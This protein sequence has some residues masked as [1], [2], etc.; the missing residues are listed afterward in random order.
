VLVSAERDQPDREAGPDVEV[1]VNEIARISAGV[2]QITLG[3]V[4]PAPLPDWTPGAH[5][6]VTFSNGVTRQ[7]S[8]CGDPGRDREYQI[9]VLRE[10]DSRGGSS[11]AHEQLQVGD[12]LLVSLPRNHFELR[13]AES[14]RFVA[15]G[16]GIT[17]L[18]PMIRSV[19]AAGRDWQLLY[20]GRTRDSMA[21]LDQLAAYGPRVIVR[22]QDEFGLLDLQSF[23]GSP[24][25]G[26]LVYC[27]GPEPL[28]AAAESVCT[29]WPP[30]AL[31]VERF[32][33]REDQPPDPSVQR[34]FDVVCQRSGVTVTVRP[35]VS[36]LEAVR[37]AGVQA[38]ST[39][40]EG[41][42]GTCETAVIE[43][44][45][46]HHDE[47]LDDEEKAENTSM[48]ICVGRSLSPTLVI[49]L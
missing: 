4:G 12:N 17:P 30:G 25:E 44:I 35:G 41:T 22:P 31:R 38:A 13:R 49:D 40:Q 46:E 16:I 21:F 1:R 39:C 5:I 23:L 18:F 28:L 10:P 43:G 33:P 32:S 45:P 9:A 14:Y 29:T 48:M 24:Q 47:V 6:D 34:T 26:T 19:A 37:A 8:L 7:Y 15:G 27:C 11:Y 36:I 42:C 3:A 20:G 2:A